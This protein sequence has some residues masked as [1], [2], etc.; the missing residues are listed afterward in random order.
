MAYRL[1]YAP[2][3]GWNPRSPS[4][5]L[6]LPAAGSKKVIPVGRIF[7]D[8]VVLFLN[9]AGELGAE[10]SWYDVFR[11]DW[12]SAGLRRAAGPMESGEEYG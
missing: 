4:A 9:G 10:S 2:P 12:M 5:I 8:R 11:G 1:W 7:R 3:R 6:G